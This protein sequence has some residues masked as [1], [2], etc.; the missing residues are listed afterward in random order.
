MVRRWGDGRK[1]ESGEQNGQYVCVQRRGERSS[2]KAHWDEDE[3][4][5]NRRI[6]RPL[7]VNAKDI[8]PT[9]RNP[10]SIAH[11]HTHLALMWPLV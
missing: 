1:R 9:I 3:D 8:Q 4:E 6:I 2:G 7:N 11:T 10:S 5:E